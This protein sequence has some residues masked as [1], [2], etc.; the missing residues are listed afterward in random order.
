MAREKRTA[1]KH[2]HA[3]PHRNAVPMVSHS[4][5][6]RAGHFLRTMW[7]ELLALGYSEP[8]LFIGVS[9]LL[10][11]G[12]VGIKLKTDGSMRQAALDP[13]TLTLPFFMY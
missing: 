5:G 3:P 8:P 10:R 4:D 1:R 6:Q 2:V 12:Y 7:T 9:R 11:A 13:G